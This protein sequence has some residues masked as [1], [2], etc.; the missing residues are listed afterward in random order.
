MDIRQPNFLL[1][2]PSKGS[3]KRRKLPRQSGIFPLDKRTAL[4]VQGCRFGRTHRS[5]HKDVETRRRTS[6]KKLAIAVFAFMM[7]A[8]LLPRVGNVADVDWLGK[9]SLL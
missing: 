3:Y 6:M 7:V 1:D 8:L 2:K 4:I 5:E 9:F